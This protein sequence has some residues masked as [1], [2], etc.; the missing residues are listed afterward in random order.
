MSVSR[1]EATE[2]PTI[3]LDAAGST[4][5]LT[6]AQRQRLRAEVTLAAEAIPL[7]WPMRTF[8]SRSPLM[9]LE[10]LPFEQ[11]VAQA[12]ELFGGEGYL[13]LSEYRSAHAAGR[14]TD[15]DLL[16]ALR[17]FEPSLGSL[18]PVRVNHHN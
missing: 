1:T 8:I 6:E 7:N 2:A 13:S 3:P 15:D 4:E 12:R 10:H 5:S 9:G 16:E 17:A 14:I 11:A 18:A